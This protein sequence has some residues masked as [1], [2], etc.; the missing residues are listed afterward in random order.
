MYKIIFSGQIADNQQLQT[1][2]NKLAALFHLEDKRIEKLFSGSPIVLKKTSDK[3]TALRMKAKI[4]K[5][6]GLCKVEKV[7]QRSPELG[8]DCAVQAINQET[9]LD[10][11]KEIECPKCG[12]KQKKSPECMRCG[13]IFNKVPPGDN[14]TMQ[15]EYSA[16]S[17]PPSQ[18]R[19]NNEQFEFYENSGSVGTLAIPLSLGAGGASACILAFI[20]QLIVS[21]NPFVYLNFFLSVFFGFGIGVASGF[22]L[23]LG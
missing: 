21:W 15:D 23:E 19:R 16:A 11:N 12:F 17:T 10:S 6:G 8:N 2:K 3:Q 4:E 18:D 5:A 13:C 14:R 1:V 7:K 20:Y 22:G 9:V